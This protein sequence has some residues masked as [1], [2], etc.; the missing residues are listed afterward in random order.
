M[1]T[2]TQVVVFGEVLFDN[3]PN[4]QQ[5]LG[6]APFNVAWHL[7]ALGDAP[8]LVSRIGR[9]LSGDRVIQ[10]MAEWGM[11]TSALQVDPA[12]PTGQVEVQFNAD[13]PNYDIV[14]N[15]AYDFIEAGNL[16]TLSS[17]TL[18]YHGTLALRNE[19]SRRAL[20]HMI[21]GA[22]RRSFLMSICVHH[23]GKENWFLSA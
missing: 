5:V 22:M 21:R 9:D 14:V 20:E 10:A 19:V 13:E 16:P 23:G 1:S 3:F 4:D 17:S 8:V 11:T 18:L 15:T 6:G 7:Q 2:A 12:R